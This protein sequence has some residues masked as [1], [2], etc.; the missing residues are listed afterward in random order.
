MGKETWKPIPDFPGYEVS[1]CGRVRSYFVCVYDQKYP[2]WEISQHPQR[3]LSPRTDK[4]GYQHVGL[5]RCG[6]RYSRPVH[7]LV[8][9]AF[10]G[11]CPDGNVCCHNDGSRANNNLSNLRYDTQKGNMKDCSFEHAKRISDSD[12]IEIRKMRASGEGNKEIARKFDTST[13]YISA[14]AR[15]AARSKVGGPRIPD[16]RLV[17]SDSDV[18][19]VREERK[20]GR[21]LASI[22]DDFGC[23]ESSISL[24]CA[25]KRRV[26]TLHHS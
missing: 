7:R 2:H 24:I 17:L 20:K 5:Q 11:R 25:G 6:I 3:I 21:A 18:M 16:G 9:L 13:G 8:M 26:G 12:V 14:I 22:A 4:D 15:R 23:S 1:D 19:Q 10:V